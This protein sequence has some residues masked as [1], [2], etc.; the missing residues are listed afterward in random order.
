MI[1]QWSNATDMSTVYMK[2]VDQNQTVLNCY[3]GRAV[4]Q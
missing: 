1:E 4:E 3:S 2:N